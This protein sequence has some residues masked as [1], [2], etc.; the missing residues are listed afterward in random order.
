MTVKDNNTQHKLKKI[1]K[2]DNEDEEREFWERH[3]STEYVNWEQDDKTEIIV[4]S[5]QS[6]NL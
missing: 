2:F 1:P 5:D 6:K 4:E 3:D